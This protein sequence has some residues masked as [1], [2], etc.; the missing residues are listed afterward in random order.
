MED[1]DNKIS[2]RQNFK[3]SDLSKQVQNVERWNKLSIADQDPEFLEETNRVISDSSI[4]DGQ[5]DN[6][7][8]NIG[9][10]SEA[11]TTVPDIHDQ[12]VVPSDAYVNMESVLPP[13]SNNGM[14]H[15]LAKQRNIYD[16][17]KPI[18]V[19]DRNQLN[20]MRAYE[21]E[22]IDGTTETLTDNIISKNLLAQVDEEVH[23]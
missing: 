4:T 9:K 13:G 19:E 15:A 23:R 7:N 2:D 17:G 21:V 16:G 14:M 11:P 1:Y 18:D 12:D 3:N 20:D 6:T 5:D 8:R 10:I 22:F